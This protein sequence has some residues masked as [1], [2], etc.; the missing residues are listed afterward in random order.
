MVGINPDDYVEITSFTHHPFYSKFVLEIESNWNNNFYLNL[1]VNDF[2]NIVDYALLH[3]YSVAWD[4]DIRDGYKNGFAVL[5]DSVNSISQLMRQN[6]FDNY[7]TIDQHNMHIIGIARNEK[8]KEFYIVKNSSDILDCGG[9]LYMSKEFFLLK[10]ISVMVNKNAI[11]TD[12]K[13]RIT[14]VL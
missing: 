7:T 12:I 2:I 9:Y 10:T 13:K 11:P 5:S 3:N 14:V 8:G 4:G 6:A 1:P